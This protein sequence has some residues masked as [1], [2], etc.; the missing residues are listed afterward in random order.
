[1]ERSQRVGRYG[2]STIKG[3]GLLTVA[4][5]VDSNVCCSRSLLLL[6][7]SDGSFGCD[8]IS[9]SR[10]VPS[11]AFVGYRMRVYG[12]E[13][14]LDSTLGTN[15]IEQT[16]WSYVKTNH[17]ANDSSNPIRDTNHEKACQSHQET[18]CSSAD[19]LADQHWSLCAHW[20][21]DRSR[22]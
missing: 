11:P 5:V 22:W 9:Y 3:I 14:K 4:A 15:T 8:W 18:R 7:N 12:L 19:T 6:L 21:S 20:K 2:V 13:K 16:N 1:L 17:R 10:R